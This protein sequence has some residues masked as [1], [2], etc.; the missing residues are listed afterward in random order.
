MKDLYAE[1]IE[2]IQAAFRKKTASLK[3]EFEAYKQENNAEEINAA[4]EAE[5]EK[6]KKLYAEQIDEIQSA[7][8][9]RNQSLQGQIDKFRQESTGLEEKIEER[10]AQL[11]KMKKL[12]A[13][14]IDEL[15]TA[16]QDKNDGSSGNHRN[17]RRR[18]SFSC[19]RKYRLS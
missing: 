3:Q 15:Q 2:E 5:L 7:F 8:R 19:T 4:H 13:E 18:G 6:M 14:Q 10:D 12:Y 9:D 11:E 17:G 1:Q 16:F